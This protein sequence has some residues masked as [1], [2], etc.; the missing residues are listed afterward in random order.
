[1]LLGPIFYSIVRQ[2]LVML[3]SRLLYVHRRKDF[4]KQIA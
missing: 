1:M 3:P 2:A 4:D